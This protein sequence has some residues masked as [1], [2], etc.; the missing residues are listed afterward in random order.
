MGRGGNLLLLDEEG[1]ILHSAVPAT[2]AR[3]PRD[4]RPGRVYEPPAPPK[5]GARAQANRFRDASSQPEQ[6]SFPVSAAI[7]AHYLPLERE[8][9]LEERRRR[10]MR[11]VKSALVRL[12]K[13]LAR[14]DEEETRAKE[15]GKYRRYGELLKTSLHEVERGAS[16]ARVVDWYADGQPETTVP[17]REDV[18][19]QENME[20]YFRL[21]RR[22]GKAG[23]K[24]AERRE[25]LLSRKP[26]LA[27]LLERIVSAADEHALDEA[28]REAVARGF[29]VPGEATRED[30]RRKPA[31]AERRPY[32]RYVSATGRAVLVGRGGADND[33]LTFKV[34]RGNDVWLHV[35]GHP[36]AHVVIPMSK[37][38]KDEPG[39]QREARG[40]RGGAGGIGEAQAGRAGRASHGPPDLK[41][42]DE[43]TLLD[44]AT[45]AAHFSGA[46]GERLVDVAWTRRKHVRKP[47]G[48][49]PG[50]VTVSGER[51][52]MLRL[53][54]ER[55]ERLL[56]GPT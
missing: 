47:K 36:G 19:P 4:L 33:E 44:A 26:R 17:L 35:R 21:A 25:E 12:D 30:A 18:S 40:V 55:L 16:E 20:R 37:G 15:A 56:A 2:R 41:E 52:L 51:G 22:L 38:K 8:G 14:L 32:R 39:L 13:A 3:P 54:P 9:E 7:E 45:L 23:E 50:L 49:R 31:V 10:I 46:R 43:Q 48:T 34:A 24:V 28:S 29:S 6:G 11:P 27:A 5:A 53:E 1:A 42:P